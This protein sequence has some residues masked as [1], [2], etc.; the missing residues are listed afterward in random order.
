MHPGGGC[1]VICL[2]VV[3][4]SKKWL[5][6]LIFKRRQLSKLQQFRIFQQAGYHATPSNRCTKKSSR[7]RTAG[8]KCLR[9]GYSA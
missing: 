5:L 8:D 3:Y 7:A 4:I 9:E 6:R 2:D 1:A